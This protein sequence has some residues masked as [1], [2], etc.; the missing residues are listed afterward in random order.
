MFS[1][2]LSNGSHLT[3]SGEVLIFEEGR[4]KFRNAN[5]AAIF[6]IGD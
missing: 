6:Y 2:L 5:L 4:E 1:V 3:G